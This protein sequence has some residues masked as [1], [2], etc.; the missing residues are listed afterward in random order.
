M[1]K[2]WPTN[3]GPPPFPVE[4]RIVEGNPEPGSGEGM[5][6]MDEDEEDGGVLGRAEGGESG[7][8]D[9]EGEVSER[10]ES[11]RRRGRWILEEGRGEYGPFGKRREDRLA[12]AVWRKPVK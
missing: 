4:I 9:S 2:T 1:L 8:A 6:L 12:A 11:G 7:G 3:A 10:T 5:F